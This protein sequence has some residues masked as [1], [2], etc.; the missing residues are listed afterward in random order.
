MGTGT[1]VGIQSAE[2]T[3]VKGDLAGIARARV[4]P[5]HDV[6]HPTESFSGLRAQW[7][8]RAD[9]G[10]PLVS[11]LGCPAK[12]RDRSARDVAEFGLCHQQR[13]AP[14]PAQA[15]R[16]RTCRLVFVQTSIHRAQFFNATKVKRV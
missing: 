13:I 10:W 15:G 2:I 9:S 16:S 4:E 8:R 11:G 6:Q 3:L 7:H 12:S 14:P 5:C 1:D